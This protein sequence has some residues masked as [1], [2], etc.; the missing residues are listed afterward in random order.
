MLP[1]PLP[2]S[3]SSNQTVCSAIFFHKELCPNFITRV[4]KLQRFYQFDFKTTEFTK[5]LTRLLITDA[6]EIL[7]I[8]PQTTDSTRS[9]TKRGTTKREEDS[10]SY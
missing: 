9:T 1:W 2:L 4:T 3:L 7:R 8:S 6:K 5:K 10:R